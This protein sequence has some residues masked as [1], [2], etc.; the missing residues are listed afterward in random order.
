MAIRLSGL[1]SGL[2]TD[3]IIKELMSVQNTKVTR[4]QNKKTKLEW[5]EEKWKE[6]NKKIYALYTDE[7]SKLK[8][9]S[10]YMT[11]KAESTNS[12]KVSVTAGT[13]VPLGT[14]EVSVSQV[15]SS[16]FVTGAEIK[17]NKADEITSSTKLSSLG[18]P[19]GSTFSIKINGDTEAKHFTVT[20]G[21]KISDLT[22]WAKDAGINLNYDEK[23]RR[24]FASAKDSG[25]DHSFTFT[26]KLASEQYQK[27][28][29]AMKDAVGYTLL[30]AEQKT[31]IDTAL[32]TIKEKDP[33]NETE[34]QAYTDAVNLLKQYASAYEK[35]AAGAKDDS[36]E[37][38]KKFQEE[39]TTA[40]A[41][42]PED[43]TIT[44]ETLKKVE[45]AVNDVNQGGKVASTGSALKNL[46][47]DEIE[48][49]D[50]DYY[51]DKEITFVK[52]SNCKVVYNGKEYES[53]SNQITIN[54]L[55][56]NAIEKTDS[57]VKINVTNNIDNVYNMVKNFVN[58]YNNVLKE[59]N[60]LYYADSAKGYDV[61]TDEEKEHMTE[62]QIEKWENKIKGSLLRRDNT[63]G[64]IRNSLISITTMK[65]EV[66]GY[67][68]M[69][70]GIGTKDYTEKGLLH[71]DG[72]KDDSATAEKDN[73]L[74][75][76]LEADPDAVM[77]TLTDIGNKL[78]SSLSEKM[79][80]TSLS[81][82][83]TFYNDK[84]ITTQKKNYETEIKKLQTKLNQMENNYYS[85]F[86]AMESALTKMN[87]NSS[88]FL[89]MLG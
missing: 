38:K 1:S 21:T 73:K 81:S 24:F 70:L 10:S 22:K 89:S 64:S 69:D 45:A 31:S 2:D 76:A 71:I 36:E 68:L 83:L 88:Y 75:Q 72:D 80:A 63:L 29:T 62:A 20:D 87:A 52:P 16:Q 53:G 65:S 12:S 44:G 13:D 18:I 39:I 85:R 41:T 60:E 25:L 11:K 46:G 6:L 59:V 77:K 48:S 57:P 32:K 55:T 67:S 49:M 8:L 56:I 42:K 79:A 84:Q 78:Y 61:L 28:D 37:F 66:T 58:A 4:I 33:N 50:P 34:K 19:A 23:N 15:A 40:L 26:S 54:G 17:Q 5:K 47:L 27:G 86:A 74:M 3:A 14:H 82:A 9:Q 43:L 51:K 7:L 30:T 35:T